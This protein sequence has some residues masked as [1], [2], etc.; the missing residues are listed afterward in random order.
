MAD[1]AARFFFRGHLMAIA[2]LLPPRKQLGGARAGTGGRRPAIASGPAITQRGSP[3]PG[4]R[5]EDG[6][7]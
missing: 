5:A 1:T 3:N 2:G 7:T 6:P 4:T